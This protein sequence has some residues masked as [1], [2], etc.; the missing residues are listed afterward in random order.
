MKS[1]A[2]ASHPSSSPPQ[3][4]PSSLVARTRPSRGANRTG[5]CIERGF[6]WWRLADERRCCA[7]LCDADATSDERRSIELEEEVVEV[8]GRRLRRTRG[9]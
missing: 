8:E 6:G 2:R 4:P 5:S 1:R 3:P 7:G 9:G